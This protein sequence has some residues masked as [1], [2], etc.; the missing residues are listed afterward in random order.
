M[1]FLPTLD[2]SQH[3]KHG[4]PYYILYKGQKNEEGTERA[5][6]RQILTYDDSELRGFALFD[7]FAEENVDILRSLDERDDDSAP[8]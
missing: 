4:T 5:D 1:Y 7:V 2:L 8:P 6:N 3:T